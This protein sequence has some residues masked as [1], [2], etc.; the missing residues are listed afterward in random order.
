M[1]SPWK[2]YFVLGFIYSVKIMLIVNQEGYFTK[3][4][5]QENKIFVEYLS[6]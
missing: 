6:K 2:L 4:K 1:F 5:L 3:K